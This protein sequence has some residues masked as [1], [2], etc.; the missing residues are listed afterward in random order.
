MTGEDSDLQVGSPGQF[1]VLVDGEVI[2]TRGGGFFARFFGG[3][4]PE[5]VAVAQLVKYTLDAGAK[6][7]VEA[8]SAKRART[9]RT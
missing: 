3:G 2:A 8:E 4:W 9:A 6:L 7:D 1:D 5:P